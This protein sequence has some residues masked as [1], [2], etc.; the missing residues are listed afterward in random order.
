ML[1]CRTYSFNR[2][3]R[4]GYGCVVS[5]KWRAIVMLKLY[6]G[7]N[8][9]IDKIDLSHS[10]KG[11]DFGRGFYLNPNKAQ[12]T[13]MAV[14]TTQRLQEGEPILNTYLFDKS[15]IRTDCLPLSV[16]V[17]E[18]YSVE[19]AD[20]ILKNRKNLSDKP[21]HHYDIVVGPIANDTVGLQMRR[22]IQG[23]ISLER[24][25][26]ELKFKKTAIQ[27]FFGTEQ[28]ISCLKKI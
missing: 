18:D 25:I 5:K 17:F 23:Y 14:R 16:K 26:E 28:A 20:F 12:A 21:I 8:V 6:H 4:G 19:W 9:V 24:M 3:C 10:K 2:G 22:F 15:L 7:S 1:S 13:D 27:Y 11:K